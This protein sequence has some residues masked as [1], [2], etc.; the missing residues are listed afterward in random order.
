MT[1]SVL[2]AS[3]IEVNALPVVISLL[4]NQSLVI[5]RIHVTQIVGR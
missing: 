5:V 4:A 1:C 3:Q 2:R